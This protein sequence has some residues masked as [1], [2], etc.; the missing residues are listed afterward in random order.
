MDCDD[1]KKHLTGQKLVD[2][3]MGSYDELHLTFENGLTLILSGGY[4]KEVYSSIKKRVI[5]YEDVD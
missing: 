4:C 2:A 1:I 5:T 3:V